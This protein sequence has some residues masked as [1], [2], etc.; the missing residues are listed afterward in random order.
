MRYNVARAAELK[1][2]LAKFPRHPLA[3][4]P[5]PI[6]HCQRLKSH[7]GCSQEIFIKRDDCTG[8]AFGGNKTRM[9]EYL[10]GHAMAENYDCIIGGAGYQSNYSRQLAASCANA[11]LECHLLVRKTQ[12]DVQHTTGNF[13]LMNLLGA[14]VHVLEEH[15]E[16]GHHV[17]SSQQD[18]MRE[19][20][21]E[22]ESQGKKVLVLRVA[23][24]TNL[25]LWSLG[26]VHAGIELLEQISDRNIGAVLTCTAD[27]THAGL[28]LAFQY[29]EADFPFVSVTPFH[30]P[31]SEYWGKT[32]NETKFNI[33]NDC[34]KLLGLDFQ[35][36]L[37]K[38]TTHDQY[39]G[40]GYG[41]L[42]PEAKEAIRILASTEGILL[43]PIYSA[44]GFAGMI[45]QI[46]RNAFPADKELVY[47]HTGG[48]PNLFVR[49]EEL[50]EK[51]NGAELDIQW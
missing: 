3:H 13:F 24:E 1:S 30:K 41:I 31:V 46:R 45:D 38:I 39:V 35:A 26:Y 36:D 21:A 5:T 9:L 18:L 34:A 40:E 19:K 49:P 6:S 16:D 33:V 32:Q 25:A 8:L 48:T 29:C 51:P 37:S 50:L 4:L 15:E 42:T 14:H 7:L 47:I 2:L 44:K 27:T 20:A 43:D 17:S 11:G 22:L 12:H 28:E 10:V 23:N